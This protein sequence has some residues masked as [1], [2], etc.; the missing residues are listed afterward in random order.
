MDRAAFWNA[1]AL[2]YKEYNELNT[3]PPT[4]I[5]ANMLEMYLADDI[6]EVACATG[7]F[8]VFNLCNLDNAKRFISV[9]VSDAMIELAEKRK[10]NTR[11]LNKKIIHSL[12]WK[13]LKIC[14]S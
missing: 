12:R 1:R 3:L 5:L 11:G 7:L 13:T 14:T 6:I 4:L 8:T 2:C 10:S 9:D